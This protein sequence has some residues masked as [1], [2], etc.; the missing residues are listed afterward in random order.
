MR[1]Q[2]RIIIA[3]GIFPP[4]IGGP[5]TYSK[6]M[7]DNL[8]ARGH[9]IRVL[10]FG[11][12]DKIENNEKGF[13]LKTISRK[14][15][16]LFRY[17]TYFFAL[18]KESRA[19][20]IIYAFDLLSVGLASAL[21]KLLKKKKLI[22]RLG[23]DYQWE[24]AVQLGLR[25]DTLKKYYRKKEFGLKEKIIYF[26]TQFVLRR[27]DCVIFN[28]NLLKDIYREYRA[29]PEAKAKIVKNIKPIM[30][31]KAEK[32]IRKN[33]I[34]ILYA[35]RFIKAR[36]I[37]R[38]IEAF[39]LILKESQPKKIIL[40]IIGEGPEEEEIKK[41]VHDKDLSAVVK[42]LPKLTRDELRKKMNE[43]DLVALV[44]LTEVNPNLISEALAFG[45]RVVL[46]KESEFYYEGRRDKSIYPAPSQNTPR[47]AAGMNGYRQ[48]S[49]SG[50]QY[51]TGR[52]GIY[53]VD[54]LDTADITEKI[55]RAISEPKEEG[56]ENFSKDDELTSWNIVK[57]IKAH[58]LIFSE[59][60]NK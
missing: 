37:L 5:A 26:L 31:F 51:P 7:A 6:L 19:I 40:E 53:Y 43:S 49:L 54:P 27:A 55:K 24:K 33:Y 20:D 12:S 57:V 10:T 11:D 50:V 58:E 48:D 18:L 3:T 23:G 41:Y 25:E 59:L 38:L 13:F 35:G 21:V 29:F 2:F 15:N 30:D 47:L 52:C 45:K 46:T 60:F 22:I 17:V 4:D 32:N 36:N 1:K 44:S 16:T 8:A 39:S 9:E 56:E 42:V 34:N 14:Q 28:A